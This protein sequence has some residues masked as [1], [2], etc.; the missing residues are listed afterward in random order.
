[1]NEQLSELLKQS[2]PEA[3]DEIREKVVDFEAEKLVRDVKK[4]LAEA[5]FKII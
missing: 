1:M 5:G 4:A 3:R 2:T